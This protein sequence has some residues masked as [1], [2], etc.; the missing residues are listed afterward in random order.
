[1]LD[2]GTS[3]G[4]YTILGSLARGGTAELYLAR[5][6]GPSGFHKVLVL[7]CRRVSAVAT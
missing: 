3:V 4:R 2:D 5:Q 6:V 7:H 1:M